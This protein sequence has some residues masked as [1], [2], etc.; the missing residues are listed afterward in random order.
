MSI[1]TEE[2]QEEF[3]QKTR[4]GYLTTL[5]SS[6]GFPRTVPVWFDWDNHKIRIF[7]VVNS[8]KLKRIEKDPRV[9][10]LAA[11]DMNE[12]E[13]WVSFEGTATIFSEGAIELVEKL[14]NKY[15]DLSNPD[16]KQTLESWK[17]RPEIFRIIEITPT[18]IRTY[19]D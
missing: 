11:N 10:V 7:S 3:L 8:L 9:T 5:S 15:W 2:Y 14:A 1:M 16:V 6:G 19:Y 13:A 18:R 12:H 4:Y 17:S